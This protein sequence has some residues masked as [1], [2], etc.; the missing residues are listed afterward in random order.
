MMDRH[1]EEGAG[2]ATTLLVVVLLTFGGLV[3]LHALITPPSPALFLF[4]LLTFSR[5]GALASLLATAGIIALIQQ[6][7]VIKRGAALL[8]LGYGLFQ[9]LWLLDQAWEHQGRVTAQPGMSSLLLVLLS[10]SVWQDSRET[11]SSDRWKRWLLQCLGGMSIACGSLTLLMISD[12]EEVPRWRQLLF[13]TRPLGT[14]MIIIFGV[15][16]LLLPRP[17]VIN[18]RVLA[19]RAVWAGLIGTSLSLL[20]AFGGYHLYSR[21]LSDNLASQLDILGSRIAQ[22]QER[23]SEGWSEWSMPLTQAGGSPEPT[24]SSGHEEIVD[25]VWWQDG[26]VLRRLGPDSGS[27]DSRLAELLDMPQVRDWLARRRDEPMRWWILAE[28][29]A[30]LEVNS[31]GSFGPRLVTLVSMGPWL[32]RMSEGL[33]AR[34]T[35][36]GWNES[37]LVEH[38]PGEVW[39]EHGRLA[40]LMREDI[41]M[42]G[43]GTLRIQASL[44]LK[45]VGVLLPAM[46]AALGLFATYQ[47]M[48]W[49]SLAKIRSRQAMSLAAREQE[50]RS[51]FGLSADPMLQVRR[52]GLVTELNASA[53]R[54][55]NQH[56]SVGAVSVSAGSSETTAIGQPFGDI[57]CRL[58]G[59]DTPPSEL[60]EHFDEVMSGRQQSVK[61]EC[62]TQHSCFLVRLQQIRVEGA[63]A[64]L[65]ASFTDVTQR[66]V[67]Q[68]RLS[69]M[70]RCLTEST[71]GV[72]IFDAI[73]RGGPV[74]YVNAAVCRM[75]GVRNADLI[76][77]KASE[78]AR[79]MGL[80]PVTE[81]E[82]CHWMKTRQAGSVT[83]LATQDVGA[84]RWYDM[85]L[86]PVHAS[87]EGVSHF[88]GIV[89][90]VTQRKAQEEML[91][92]QATH[93]ALT[94]LPN[95]LLLSDRLEH[96]VALAQRHE[97]GLAVLFL[98]LDAFK[99]INDSL[100]HETGDRV[101][102]QVAKRLG[103]GQRRSDTLARLGGDEFVMV[104]V[105][106][107]GR[108]EA[109]V[110]AERLLEQLHEPFRV[111]GHQLHISA[112]IGIAM[113]DSESAVSSQRLIQ[114]A[115]LAM[116]Q[117]KQRGRNQ[118]QLFSRT[119]EGAS[120]RHVM[121][122]NALRVALDQ[123]R[124]QVFY[125]P[126]VDGAGRV[127][128]LEALARW[129]H[130]DLGWVSPAEFIPL[131]EETGQI[132]ELGRW[133]LRRACQDAKR[134]LQLGLSP[135]RVAV[136]LSPL[137]FHREDFL[138]SVCQALDDIQL[139]S[140]W[141]ELEI[142]EGMLLEDKPGVAKTLEK[143]SRRGVTAA[144]DDFG[145]GYSSFD[146]LKSLP[147]DKI[148]ID[149]GFVAH[150]L[151]SEPDLAVCRSVISLA[152]ELDLEVLAEGVETARHCYTLKQ[153][154]CATFQG[155]LFSRPVP[156][157]E[158]DALLRR[159]HLTPPTA[160]ESGEVIPLVA[161]DSRRP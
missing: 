74:I 139:P 83:V 138:S 14:L 141:L 32:D 61:F 117:A 81:G 152:R 126:Q 97:K 15:I 67:E 80:D 8:L 130:P 79:R 88:I 73:A 59:C 93:D 72:V 101:L 157:R 31:F 158:L 87:R 7:R 35:L 144:I 38:R 113:L 128:G 63:C 65:F 112:S 27:A 26:K 100:G 2:L 114:Q 145:T 28:G 90:D 55:L 43:G 122:R 36:I 4:E 151:D 136:N 95:R 127:T 66:Q 109:V 84:C 41:A 149:R 56:A 147:I 45:L 68:A 103:R 9:A 3:A 102:V 140:D 49:I 134:L 160:A 44:P 12:A 6:R 137:E 10:V 76:G 143:L 94:G 54:A 108:E 159:E 121:L 69:I 123:Q 132:I 86:S 124:L 20:V 13:E 150:C 115:D 30:L 120:G 62:Y 135:G 18:F 154:G 52:S 107:G 42:S 21:S 119:L 40:G 156:F 64:G 125:Q 51:L 71:N 11:E 99:P 153:L 37:M 129:C 161:T 23:Y 142:T 111:D 131:A 91:A 58:M 70:E 19:P 78:L 118:C 5:S 48:V 25:Y 92:H 89:D 60:H 1:K 106:I 148:K 46:L 85:T 33:E 133:I 57:A 34:M 77:L 39:V 47:L 53:E 29:D 104:L 116:Y 16:L 75:L 105:D 17:D 82:I 146:Y 155:Y 50:F 98:D 24:G 22:W 96:D 110:V